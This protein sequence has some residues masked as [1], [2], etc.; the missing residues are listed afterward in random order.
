MRVPSSQ[1]TLAA[2]HEDAPPHFIERFKEMAKSALTVGLAPSLGQRASEVESQQMEWLWKKHIPLGKL[3]IVEGDPGVG[4]STF[5]L[6][7]LAAAVSTGRSMPDGSAGTLGGVV[8]L[9]AEEGLG[10]TI[11]PRLAAAGADLDRILLYNPFHTKEENAQI[12]F[13]EYAERLRAMIRKVGAKLVIIDPLTA[14]LGKGISA[15]ND[16]E[17]RK[18]LVSLIEIAET[19]DATIILIRHLNKSSV[20]S[21]LYRGAGSVAISGA[22]RVVYHVGKHPE[23]EDPETKADDGR[24]VLAATKCNIGPLPP[25]WVFK[26]LPDGD[27]PPTMVWLGTEALSADDLVQGHGKKEAAPPAEKLEE[28][29][30]FLQEHLAGGPQ[31]LGMLHNLRTERGIS[32]STFKRAAKELNVKSLKTDRKVVRWALPE[33]EEIRFDRIKAEDL[34]PKSAPVDWTDQTVQQHSRG[35]SSR[36]DAPISPA[37]PSFIPLDA[38]G[39]EKEQGLASEG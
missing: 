14:F 36:F 27:G 28:A 6:G 25:S 7:W 33:R 31:Y 16:Q 26:I 4:K 3:V 19:E 8:L 12:A 11:R 20:Q 34:D 5:L 1:S 39:A 17:V 9:T 37:P 15:N 29:K 24:R 2:L 32:E 22:A 21:G 35:T 10:D 30:A 13:P 38:L 23:S 18:A